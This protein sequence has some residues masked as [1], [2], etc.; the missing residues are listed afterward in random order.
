M[1]KHVTRRGVFAAL[2]A[3]AVSAAAIP[4]A[5]ATYPGTT[6][7]RLAFGITIDGNPDVYSVLP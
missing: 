1:T 6:D 7:G 5:Q 4:S 3:A 2:A